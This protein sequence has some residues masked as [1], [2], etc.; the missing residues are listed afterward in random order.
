M[1]IGIDAHILGK[2]SGGVE[3]VVFQMVRQVPD[4]LPGHS[5]IIFTNRSYRPPFP[6]RPN[7]RYVSLLLS[8]PVI[9][10]SLLLPWLV[11]R[12]RLDLL[13][14]Q[15][16]APPF[17][18]C[19]LVVSIHD[20]L[21]LTDRSSHPGW[22]DELVRR[23][24]PGSIRRADRIVTVSNTVR[25]EL[26]ARFPESA[27]RVT[28]IYNG[29]DPEFYQDDDARER[30]RPPYLLCM[31][32]IA[33]RKNLEV[34]LRAFRIFLKGPRQAR[35]VLAGLIRSRAYQERLNRLVAELD[36][37]GSVTFTGFISDEDYRLLLQGARLFLAPSRGEGFDLPALEAGASGR[38][39]ICSDIPVHRELLGDGAVFF[40]PDDAE[41]LARQIEDLW[42]RE[43]ERNRLGRAARQRAADFSWER[44]AGQLA[45]L[46]VEVGK[47]SLSRAGNEILFP[48]GIPSAPVESQRIPRLV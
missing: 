48:P 21:P 28:A 46:Y 36:L 12:W 38:A 45:A 41:T 13:H 8:D 29:I 16:I 19:R 26:A 24:T 22:R 47:A 6:D 32:A 43:E 17:P 30:D 1:R 20:I 42:E 37:T 23:L 14:V 35:L 31:G 18:G 39:V 44:M 27:G 25:D 33:P 7:V 15:R 34:V 4:L 9:Q 10:R 40:P 5:F 11:R 2:G 3:R